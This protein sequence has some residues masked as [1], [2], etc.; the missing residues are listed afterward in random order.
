MDSNTATERPVRMVSNGEH[1]SIVR[2]NMLTDKE[3]TARNR[4]FKKNVNKGPGA[5]QNYQEKP[6]ITEAQNG[7]AGKAI[8]GKIEQ[9][10]EVMSQEVK[11]MNT[12][13]LDLAQN[14]CQGICFT[15]KM[16]C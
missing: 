12:G 15:I 11:K 5:K 9:F 16:K 4:L 6:T 13:R 14:R 1:E 10:M 7:M 2:K 8:D 3:Q